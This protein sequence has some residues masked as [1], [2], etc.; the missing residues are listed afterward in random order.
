MDAYFEALPLYEELGHSMGIG[1]QYTNMAYVHSMR[2]K[3]D[4]ALELYQKALPLYTEVGDGRRIHLTQKNINTLQSQ[5][6][7]KN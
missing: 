3:L 1:D 7:G 2:G 6:S 5:I 4:K